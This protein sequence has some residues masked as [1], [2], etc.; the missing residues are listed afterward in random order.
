MHLF[1]C[2]LVVDV[3]DLDH[4]LSS[5]LAPENDH[6][7]YAAGAENEPVVVEEFFLLVEGDVLAID[8]G[9]VLSLFRQELKEDLADP[10]YRAVDVNP[11][12][13]WM[14]TQSR[15]HHIRLR[16]SVFVANDEVLAVIL[17]PEG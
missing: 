17:D 9:V 1:Y 7:E 16:V 5:L 2:E 14:Y 4:R 11:G 3:L 12:M 13:I 15:E 6:Q 10:I 8:V